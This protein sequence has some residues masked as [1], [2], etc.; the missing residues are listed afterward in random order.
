MWPPTTSHSATVAATPPPVAGPGL[1]CGRLKGTC[2]HDGI[3]AA[4]G[5][6]DLEDLSW[7]HGSPGGWGGLGWDGLDGM[8][9]W[10]W[11]V[12]WLWMDG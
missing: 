6:R 11:L 5:G 8:D 3:A 10:I 7:I 2:R 9:G 12:G 1:F 4:A